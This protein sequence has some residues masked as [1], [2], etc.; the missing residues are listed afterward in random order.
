VI[1]G[2]HRYVRSAR[3]FIGS[4]CR[5]AGVEDAVR[6]PLGLALTEILNNAIDHGHAVSGAPLDV[7]LRVTADRVRL[8]VAETGSSGWAGVD[9]D[10]AMQEAKRTSLDDTQFRG[11]GLLLVCS[12]MDE[13][14]VRSEPGS[15]TVV[16]VVKYR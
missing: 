12:L 13:M 7:E 3:R 15:G 16:E 5:V 6:D 9:L 8:V 2:R 1:P 11:R 14:N 10:R 4:V